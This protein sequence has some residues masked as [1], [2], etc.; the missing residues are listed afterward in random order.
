MHILMH[1][2]IE[3]H[4]TEYDINSN[5]ILYTTTDAGA[6]YFE[7]KIVASRRQTTFRSCHPP[8]NLRLPPLLFLL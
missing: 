6:D 4:Q 8:E 2:K 7:K 5:S 3:M 1:E